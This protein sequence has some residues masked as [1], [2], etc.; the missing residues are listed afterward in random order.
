[1]GQLLSG[2]TQHA[3]DAEIVVVEGIW[4]IE[5]NGA[6]LASLLQNTVEEGK[7]CKQAAKRR[8]LH[9]AIGKLW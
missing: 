3:P 5:A 6:K 9:A 2:R 8:M 1:M 7:T 4:C